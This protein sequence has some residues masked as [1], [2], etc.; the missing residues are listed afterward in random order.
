MVREQWIMGC[1]AHS[2]VNVEGLPDAI[3]VNRNTGRISPEW[4]LAKKME[5]TENT[6]E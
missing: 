5:G 2:W 4:E 6:G 3:T 1:L